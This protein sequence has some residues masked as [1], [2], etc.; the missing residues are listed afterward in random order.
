[1]YFRESALNAGATGA[2][3]TTIYTTRRRR[4]LFQFSF[5]DVLS[6]FEWR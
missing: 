3:E 2:S 1:M 6:L 4:R 5:H